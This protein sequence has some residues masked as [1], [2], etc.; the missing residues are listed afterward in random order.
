MGS[1]THSHTPTPTPRARVPECRE[2]AEEQEARETG[3][4]APPPPGPPAAGTGKQ[5]QPHNRKQKASNHR[6]E[7]KASARPLPAPHGVTPHDAWACPRAMPSPTHSVTHDPHPTATQTRPHFAHGSTLSSEPHSSLT[8]HCTHGRARGDAVRLTT[9]PAPAR[10]PPA[11]RTPH[12]PCT[13]TA[14]GGHL[15]LFARPQPRRRP[16]CSSPPCTHRTRAIPASRAL[17]SPRAAS[18]PHT[19][20]RALAHTPEIP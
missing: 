1:L 8:P 11:H 6:E 12:T 3:D 7:S 15:V 9:H 4:R 10:H 17:V 2:C 19:P 5:G 16:R 20:A 14:P 13:E 18:R